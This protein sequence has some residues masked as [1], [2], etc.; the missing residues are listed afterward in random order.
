MN[1][2]TFHCSGSIGRWTLAGVSEVIGRDALRRILAGTAQYGWLGKDDRLYVP[3]EIDYDDIAVLQ[4]RLLAEYGPQGTRGILLRS[5][6][7]GFSALM[8]APNGPHRL[9]SL[10]YR[11]QSLPARLRSGLGE[12]AACL[13]RETHQS[14]TVMEEAGHWRWQM[15]ASPW[16]QGGANNPA[17]QECCFVGG[18]LQE[19]FAWTSGGRY[20]PV[21]ALAGDGAA[22]ALRIE[23]T[24][25]D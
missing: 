16:S 14:I 15:Q 20:Y 25:V 24:P 3:A 19:F 7:A 1:S 21:R 8:G 13:Q 6:R 12:L 17:A 2:S 11:L 5:G 18:L 23:K 10:G 9:L 22:C 4:D